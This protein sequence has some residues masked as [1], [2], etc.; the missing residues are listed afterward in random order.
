[1]QEHTSVRMVYF[2]FLSP[3]ESFINTAKASSKKL[4]M[5]RMSHIIFCC[6]PHHRA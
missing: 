1:M 6:P 5:T 3:F 4:A 2:T